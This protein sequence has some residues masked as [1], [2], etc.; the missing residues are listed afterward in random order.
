[1]T[2]VIAAPLSLISIQLGP[3]SQL[4]RTL[5]ERWSIG[6]GYR[7]SPACHRHWSGHSGDGNS[8]RYVSIPRA[9]VWML[10]TSDP[11]ASAEEMFAA[12]R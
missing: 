8:A 3:Q 9:K 7:A 6:A 5:S 2:V 1:M 4:D 11:A 10:R 12:E